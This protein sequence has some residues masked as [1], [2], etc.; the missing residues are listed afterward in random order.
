M[1]NVDEF[2]KKYYNV[3]KSDYDTDDELKEAKKKEFD[4]KQFELGDKINKELKLTALPKW[5]SSKNDFNEARKLIKDIRADT[6]KDKSNSGDEKVFNDLNG[7]IN[8]IEN[9]KTTRKSAIK[10]AK[11]IILDLDQQRQKKVLFFKIR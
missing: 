5:L 4:Y 10:K 6:N 1:K 11:S 7:L 9:K 3:Y 8:D 2:Y